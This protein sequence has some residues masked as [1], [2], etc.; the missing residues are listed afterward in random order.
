MGYPVGKWQTFGQAKPSWSP[1]GTLIVYQ[2]AYVHPTALN[3]MDAKRETE[4]PTDQNRRWNVNRPGP[5]RPTPTVHAAEATMPAGR[6]ARRLGLHAHNLYKC[7]PTSRG[8]RAEQRAYCGRVGRL[9]LAVAIL[10]LSIVAVLHASTG[11]EDPAGDYTR[12]A[13]ERTN[14]HIWASRSERSQ[15]TH[16]RGVFCARTPGRARVGRLPRHRPHP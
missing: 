14:T 12:S 4:V 15:H 1:D 7:S 10:G 16:I 8:S 5:L 6:H 2:T 11:Y 9:A 3:I 13:P